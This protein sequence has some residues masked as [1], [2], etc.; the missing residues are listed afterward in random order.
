MPLQRF[1]EPELPKVDFNAVVFERTPTVVLQSMVVNDAE[2]NTKTGEG[3]LFPHLI[4]SGSELNRE[5]ILEETDQ[6]IEP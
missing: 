1:T 6:F 2:F 3:T 5:Q 4:G